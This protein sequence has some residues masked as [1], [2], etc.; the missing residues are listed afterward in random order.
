MQP[1]QPQVQAKH[2]NLAYKCWAA[3]S[4]IVPRCWDAP[5]GRSC[6]LLGKSTTPDCHALCPQEAALEK[7]Q[8][9][10][11]RN[12][13]HVA[14]EDDST[15]ALAIA[16]RPKRAQRKRKTSIKAEQGGD[17]VAMSEQAAAEQQ[18]TQRRGSKRPVKEKKAAAEFEAAGEPQLKKQRQK[19]RGAKQSQPMPAGHCH[20]HPPAY[21]SANLMKLHA[22]RATC[23]V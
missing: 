3:Q 10:E 14:L 11:G 20:L 17:A 19:G 8:A 21:I 12:V 23:R 18:S 13:E 9:G 16:Q 2:C 5:D 6:A 4:E 1:K 15:L 7:A 22:C